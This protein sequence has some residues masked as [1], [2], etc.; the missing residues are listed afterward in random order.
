LGEIIT[1]TK[2]P[3][4]C[5]IALLCF[6]FRSDF[7]ISNDSLIFIGARK[8]YVPPP[9]RILTSPESVKSIRS[10]VCLGLP[11]DMLDKETIKKHF[12]QFGRITRTTVTPAK[13]TATIHFADHVSIIRN[14]FFEYIPVGV[15]GAFIFITYQVYFS[16][17]AN[18]NHYFS[19]INV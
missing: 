9:Q 10:I 14:V 5:E 8:A 7:R 2:N 6:Y 4:F 3:V 17:N 12:S 19:M 18:L 15:H 11:D 16:F 13:A 1:S